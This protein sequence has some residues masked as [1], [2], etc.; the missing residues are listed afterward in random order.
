MIVKDQREALCVACEMERRAI[1][2]YQRALTLTDKPEVRA[3]IQEILKDEREHLRRFS[4]VREQYCGI[5]DAEER[6]LIA[7]M[8]AEA[9]FPGGVMEMRRANSLD[10]LKNLYTF[11]RDSEA[12]AVRAYGEFAD[13]CEHP[14]ARE[15]FLAI[16]REENITRAAQ[17]LHVTQ[18][19]LSRQIMQLEEELGVKLFVRSNHNIILTEAGM[20]LKRRAQELVAL[21]DKTKRDFRHKAEELAGE[22]AIGSGEFL[23]TSV[24]SRM[25]GS[26]RQEH[27]LVRY[28]IYSGNA[29][30]IRDSIERGLLD[31]GVMTEPVDI[32][33]YDFVPMPL[34]EIWGVL[35][36]TDSELAE[37]EAVR[38]E[39]LAGVPLITSAGD[40][41]QSTFGK[42]FGPLYDR[43]NIVATGNLLYNEAMLAES[44]MGVV[45]C[46]RLNCTYQNLRF[47]PLAPALETN[48]VLAWKKDQVFAPATAAFI[49]YARQYLSSISSDKR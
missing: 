33:K 13:K 46:I 35:V 40:F 16:A 30:N 21:A 11:A 23:S 18:P 14:A 32:R 26:F 22:I 34:N 3:G 42:W 25:M 12:D 28:Q 44:G 37:R 6:L 38:P 45:L 9:L 49:D 17:M 1:G 2:I 48:T 47:I 7:A 41:V 27:P 10:S 39:D 24:F 31:L 19:T 29:D 5:T 36:R 20:L 43:I 8:G 15:A 4:Q